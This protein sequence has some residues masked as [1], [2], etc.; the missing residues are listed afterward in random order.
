MLFACCM[1]EVTKKSGG[2]KGKGKGGKNKGASSSSVDEPAAKAKFKACS[3]FFSF[4]LQD[5]SS[6]C[7]KAPHPSVLPFSP[8]DDDDEEEVSIS[9]QKSCLHGCADMHRA[10]VLQSAMRPSSFDPGIM[11]TPLSCS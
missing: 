2:K 4:F 11:Q 3:S 6:S 8:E 1:Q 5:T 9:W 7:S 10:H